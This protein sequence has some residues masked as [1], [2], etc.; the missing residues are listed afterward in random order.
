MTTTWLR[1]DGDAVILRLHVLPGAK[2]SEVTG[3]HGEGSEARLRIRLAAPPVDG[4]ANAEL[5]RFLADAFGVALARVTFVR[6]EASRQ[7][8]VQVVSPSRRPAWSR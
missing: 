4:K 6:G 7:K 8:T 5:R 3:V 1:E 2:R